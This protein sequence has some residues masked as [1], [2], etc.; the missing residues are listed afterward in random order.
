MQN[1]NSVGAIKVTDGRE[2]KNSAHK[3]SPG[4]MV[5]SAD[6]F[7]PFPS[8]NEYQTTTNCYLPTKKREAVQLGNA[9]PE[10]A[11][12]LQFAEENRSKQRS[13]NNIP[14]SQ[15][16]TQLNLPSDFSKSPYTKN[17]EKF[18]QP[19]DH[20]GLDK[21]IKSSYASKSNSASNI[22]FRKQHLF[23]S[24]RQS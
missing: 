3:T 6:K 4:L 21:K 18:K 1:S 2:S 20:M 10:I 14:L 15:Y 19:T 13:S 24:S 9:T 11:N 5:R 7:N 17:P 12:N 16:G 8:I 22:L 23:W